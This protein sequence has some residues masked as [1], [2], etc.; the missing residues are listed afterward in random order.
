MYKNMKEVKS[1]KKKK[2]NP[3]AKPTLHPQK[4]RR[5]QWLGCPCFGI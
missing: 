3:I 2:K 4:E 1:K 5:A